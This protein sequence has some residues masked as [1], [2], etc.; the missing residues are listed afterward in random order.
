[1]NYLKHINSKVKANSPVLYKVVQLNWLLTVICLIGMILDARSLGGISV[2]TKPLKF[3]IS[4]GIYILSVGF[5]IT[6]YPF[7]N[8][9]KNIITGLTAWTLLIEMGVIFVQGARGVQSHYN[10]SS[11]LDALMYASMGVMIGINVLI[12]ILFIIETVRLKL[13]VT[14]A[15]QWSILLGWIVIVLGSWIG[16]QMIA[17]LSHS[18]GVADGGSG[19]PILNWSTKGGDLRIA[20]FFSIHGLQLIPIIAF[21]LDRKWDTSQNNR[22]IGVTLITLVYVGLIGFVFY[23]AK[24]GLPLINS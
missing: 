13:K 12:M 24:Q 2:W 11:P 14:K 6:F 8:K 17:Q 3:A 4:T 7:S 18:I 15:Q 16:G 1:M 10:M 5:L 19:I 21:I 23:Q 20:H 9:K 22:I